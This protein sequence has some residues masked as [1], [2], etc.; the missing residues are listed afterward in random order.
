MKILLITIHDSTDLKFGD[1]VIAS[2]VRR[3]LS[4]NHSVSVFSKREVSCVNPLLVAFRSLFFLPKS[5]WGF[6]IK[7]PN[8]LKRRFDRVIF[9]GPNWLV[10]HR[11]FS[12]DVFY[13]YDN[14]AL[15]IAIRVKNN[16]TGFG[17][18]QMYLRAQILCWNF[19]MK[20]AFVKKVLVSRKDHLFGVLNGSYKQIC[21]PNGIKYVSNYSVTIGPKVHRIGFFGSLDSEQSF[22]ALR[23]LVELNTVFIQKGVKPR[24]NIY[25]ARASREVVDLCRNARFNFIGP[26]ESIETMRKEND[27]FLFPMFSGTGIKNRILE[28]I[29]G[30]LPFVTN[31]FAVYGSIDLP[32]ELVIASNKSEDWFHKILS[33]S[34]NPVLVSFSTR[35]LSWDFRLKK[36]EELL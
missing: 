13:I 15:N 24:F 35:N 11:E 23:F 9:F 1:T 5:A 36:L 12:D 7:D 17:F 10:N 16:Q 27:I 21:I 4:N 31:S 2:E 30:N 28:S 6:K 22:R 34:D 8:E 3:T 26:Y 20:A 18:Y 19:L 25:G 33:F 29:S 14:M 32:D